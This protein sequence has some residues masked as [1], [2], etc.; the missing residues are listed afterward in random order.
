MRALFIPIVALLVACASQPTDVTA[1][2]AE[3]TVHAAQATATDDAPA[4]DEATPKAT[5]PHSQAHAEAPHAEAD[6]DAAEAAHG[7]CPHKAAQAK[8]T[9]PH[10]GAEATAGKTCP[11]SGAE[12]TH[13]S[14]E[15]AEAHSD[16]C[17]KGAEGE[18]AHGDCCKKGAE[19]EHAHGDC[20][21]KG[22]EAKK[23]CPHHAAEEAEAEVVPEV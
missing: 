15:G 6:A 19:G 12:A 20:C 17:K 21:K 14:A 10:S 3:H 5:C 2:T 1:V 11:Y 4:E 7:D 13:A 16:C 8:K 9:C 18:H 23:T 22:A